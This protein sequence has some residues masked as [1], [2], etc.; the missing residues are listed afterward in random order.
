[1]ESTEFIQH[2]EKKDKKEIAVTEGIEII[3]N[4]AVPTP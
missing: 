1:M 4:K 3:N 2:K